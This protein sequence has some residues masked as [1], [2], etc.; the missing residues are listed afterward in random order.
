MYRGVLQTGGAT[1]LYIA[2][3]K[4]RLECVRALLDRGAAINQAQVGCTNWM[5]EHCEAACKGMCIRPRTC[6]RSVS[7]AMV[8]CALEGLCEW[9]AIHVGTEDHRDDKLWQTC[10]R[11]CA[12]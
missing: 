11:R 5:A 6:M 3:R 8:R 2:S 12:I 7:G 9:Y 10:G 1:P 4:G